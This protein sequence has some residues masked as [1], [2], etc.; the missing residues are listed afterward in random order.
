VTK[1]T[2]ISLGPGHH[3]DSHGLWKPSPYHCTIP[4]HHRPPRSALTA[5][6]HLSFQV[7]KQNTMPFVSHREWTISNFLISEPCDQKNPQFLKTPF[8]T[9]WMD[10]EIVTL[11]EVSQTEK[12]KYCMTSLIFRI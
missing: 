5:T 3:S 6:E 10:L 1:S 2:N 4:L 11:S 8:A 7:S 9:T 12:E